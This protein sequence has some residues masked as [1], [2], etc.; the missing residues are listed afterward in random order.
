MSAIRQIRQ[1]DVLLTWIPEP[2]GAVRALGADGQPLAGLRVPGERTSHEHV[3]P[4]RVYDAPR[5][6]RVLLLERPTEMQV[7]DTRTGEIAVL[8]D[9]RPRHAPVVV[10]AGW[11]IPTTQQQYVPRS[12][13]VSR[14]RYD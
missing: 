10:R 1:G 14:A 4:A 6:G 7:L 13:P 3:L 5:V 11:W 12:R 9:G 8:P 2:H